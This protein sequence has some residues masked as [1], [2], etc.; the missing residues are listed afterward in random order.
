[1]NQLVPISSSSRPPL[2]AAAGERASIRF[3]EFF[4]GPVCLRSGNQFASKV[5][6]APDSPLEGALREITHSQ[7]KQYRFKSNQRFR[8][9]QPLTNGSQWCILPI[10]YRPWLTSRRNASAT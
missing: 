2:V 7:S 3:L 9:S 1:M 6:F 8:M 4:A 10:E 5:R